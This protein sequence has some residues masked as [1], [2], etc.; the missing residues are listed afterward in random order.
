MK[1]EPHMSDVSMLYGLLAVFTISFLG[2]GPV[3]LPLTAVVLWLGQFHFPMLVATAGTL[4]GWL[5]LEGV[6]RRWVL[7]HPEITQKIPVAYQKFFLRRT[8]FWLFVFNALPFPL[9]FMRFLALLNHYNRARLLII[10]TLS[11]LVRNTML[12]MIGA[13]LAPHQPL[14]WGAMAAFIAV[15]LLVGK[16]MQWLP[17]P[18]SE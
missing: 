14:L 7:R 11:R 3:P 13:A 6:L 10:L 15:P 12:V 16:L 8:G 4:V 2:S 17:K 1:R 18:L 5:C 9:D